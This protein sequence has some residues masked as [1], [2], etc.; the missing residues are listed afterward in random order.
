MDRI[1]IKKKNLPSKIE[2]L[3]KLNR[4]EKYDIPVLVWKPPA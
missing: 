1:I 4:T 3:P 2:C